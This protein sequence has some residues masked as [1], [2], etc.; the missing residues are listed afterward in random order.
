MVNRE[1]AG[2]GLNAFV[3][4]RNKNQEWV[5]N[6]LHRAQLRFGKAHVVAGDLDVV[7]ILERLLNCIVERECD[8]VIAGHAQPG[9][10]WQGRQGLRLDRREDRIDGILKRLDVRA[11]RFR[12]RAWH[13]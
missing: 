4:R 12:N 5:I 2:L 7:V 3:V 9:H 1:P 10:V 13:S 8:C 6:A 11:R